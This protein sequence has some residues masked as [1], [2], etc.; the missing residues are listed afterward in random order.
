MQH[1]PR[2][3]QPLLIT[4]QYLFSSAAI[5]IVAGSQVLQLDE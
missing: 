2:F 3:G 1:H 5:E 4:G